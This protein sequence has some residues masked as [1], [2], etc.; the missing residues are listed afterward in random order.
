MIVQI[1]TVAHVEKEL[2]AAWLQHLRDFDVAHPGSHFQVAV[3]APDA[4][5]KEMVDALGVNPAFPYIQI[6]RRG[7]PQ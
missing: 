3:D 1:F 7:G 6:F 4:S 2:V 5:I